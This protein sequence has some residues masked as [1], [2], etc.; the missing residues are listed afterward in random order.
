LN[1]AALWS[2]DPTGVPRARA[3]SGRLANYVNASPEQMV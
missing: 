2:V 1:Q 3:S